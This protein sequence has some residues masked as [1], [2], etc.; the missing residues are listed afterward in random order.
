LVSRS[1]KNRLKMSGSDGGSNNL[2]Q[3]FEES[4]Q[5]GKV[6]FVHSRGWKGLVRS[7]GPT[8]WRR[9]MSKSFLVRTSCWAWPELNVRGATYT[10]I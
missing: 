4:F 7:R 10:G 5:V 1:K 3:D 2:V 9:I 6:V 8:I